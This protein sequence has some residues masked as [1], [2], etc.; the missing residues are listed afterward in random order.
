M[1]ESFK[2]HM[3]KVIKETLNEMSTSGCGC[4]GASMTPGQGE[5]Y[6]SPRAFKKKS[7]KPQTVIVKKL[8]NE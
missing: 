3:I 1:N 8:W 6:A 5:Q 2:K 4:A 7:K